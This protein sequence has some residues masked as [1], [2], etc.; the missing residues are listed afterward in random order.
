MQQLL[1]GGRDSVSRM[2][3]SRSVQKH[4]PPPLL[5]RARTR[6]RPAGGRAARAE[7]RRE[8][9]QPAAV[10][11]AGIQGAGGAGAL[12]L[13]ARHTASGRAGADAAKLQAQPLHHPASC[14][15]PPPTCTAL[16]PVA[17]LPPPCLASCSASRTAGCWCS[18]CPSATGSGRWGGESGVV[19]GQQC[20][21]AQ[22]AVGL[23]AGLAC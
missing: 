16:I 11:P 19:G 14:G 2:H 10:P 13:L 9:G 1:V 6:A 21:L 20:A 3:S 23:A 18:S 15:P 17:C 8:A 7:R 22:H 4:P 12:C 5:H